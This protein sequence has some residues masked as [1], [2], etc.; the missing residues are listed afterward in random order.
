MNG[1]WGSWSSY[2]LCTK[3]CGTGTQERFRECNNPPPSENGNECI[4]STEETR[5][6]NSK[7][8]PSKYKI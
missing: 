7:S 8:C 3:S 2:S 5:H 4:G 1:Q 6:C